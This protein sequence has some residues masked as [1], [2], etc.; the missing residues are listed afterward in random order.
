MMIPVTTPLPFTDKPMH[1]IQKKTLD[2]VLKMI[3]GTGCRYK[4]VTPTGEEYGDLKIAV[5]PDQNIIKVKPQRAKYKH[6]FEKQI[7]EL[8]V[9]EVAVIPV[10]DN[11]LVDN[12]QAAI[13]GF[14]SNALGIGSFRT[15]RINGNV[16]VVRFGEV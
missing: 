10:P 8:G 9:G 5:E 7:L 1:H 13:S 16:E 15:C 6:L 4:I 12:F 11:V 3:S 2:D 14:C